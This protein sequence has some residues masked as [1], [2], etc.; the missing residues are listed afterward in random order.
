MAEGTQLVPRA[1]VEAI[2]NFA[3]SDPT[4]DF[5]GTLAGPTGV[6]ARAEV[7]LGIKYLNGAGL[8]LS[9]SYDGIGAG[10]YNS[11][12]GEGSLKLP[13]D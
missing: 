12:A 3:G 4:S 13:F 2:W 5:G 9:V 11:T 10:G 7:G 8:D 1:S 6:R